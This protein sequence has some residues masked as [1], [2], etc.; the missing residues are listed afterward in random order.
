ME[1]LLVIR[2]SLAQKLRSFSYTCNNRHSGRASKP[3]VRLQH[4][5]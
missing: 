2:M 4:F 5:L 1:S 3:P